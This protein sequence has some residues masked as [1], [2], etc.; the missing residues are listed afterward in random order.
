MGAAWLQASCLA[1]NVT[2]PRQITTRGL[3]MVIWGRAKSV[4]AFV[5]SD[6]GICALMPPGFTKGNRLVP[7]PVT[8]V[9]AVV[10]I[11]DTGVVSASGAGCV[12]RTS[13]A[14]G[15]HRSRPCSRWGPVL[16]P[17]R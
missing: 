16:I 12:S 9:R 5:R 14:C 15:V 7:Y 10:V 8:L 17:R 3:M 2:R 1:V 11:P 4:A 13:R 6:I